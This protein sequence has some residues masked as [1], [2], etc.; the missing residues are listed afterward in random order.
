M[1]SAELEAMN[2][3]A[4]VGENI[5]Y[6]VTVNNTGSGLASAIWLNATLDDRLQIPLQD[7]QNLTLLISDLPR[8]NGTVIFFNAT[9]RDNVVH[10]SAVPVG[11]NLEYSDMGE[12]IRSGSSNSVLIHGGLLKKSYLLM[13][14][15]RMKELMMP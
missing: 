15:N 4:D 14:L 11:L 1:V 2:S 7:H 10:G 3:S 9:L 5:Q 12:F 8:S 13:L 6:K